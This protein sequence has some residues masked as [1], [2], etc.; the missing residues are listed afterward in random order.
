MQE[1]APEVG[2]ALLKLI[3]SLPRFVGLLALG[4]LSSENSSIQQT[5]T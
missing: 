5:W 1:V 2:Q 4:Y 3:C